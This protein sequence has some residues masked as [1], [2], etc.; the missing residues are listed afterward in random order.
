MEESRGPDT[1]A[2]EHL[3]VDSKE[4]PESTTFDPD[5]ERDL[6][7]FPLRKNLT[8]EE[9]ALVADIVALD[10]R[11]LG[12]FK[13]RSKEREEIKHL[14]INAGSLGIV[15]GSTQVGRLLVEK[16]ETAYLN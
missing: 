5:Y 16:A 8:P 13:P 14:L 15:N 1:P 7:R 4:Q 6:V 2:A 11:S 12:A 10:H 9:D 3:Q